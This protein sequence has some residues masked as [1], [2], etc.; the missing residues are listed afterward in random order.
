MLLF[1]NGLLQETNYPDQV[2]LSNLQTGSYVFKLTVNDSNGKSDDAKVT[3]LVLNPQQTSCECSWD[4]YSNN[5]P[6]ACAEPC[7]RVNREFG[8]F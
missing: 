1:L 7:A 3:V 2:Q 5:K 4:M 8:Q 6:V